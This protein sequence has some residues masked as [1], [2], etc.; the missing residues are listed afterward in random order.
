MLEKSENGSEEDRDRDGYHLVFKGFDVT[1]KEGDSGLGIHL[2]ST[3]TL[4][5]HRDFERIRGRSDRLRRAARDTHLRNV[6]SSLPSLPSLSVL[7]QST[8]I[9]SDIS[10]KK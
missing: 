5:R 9:L 2:S 3:H 8:P 10:D 4:P 7:S 6:R 1:L